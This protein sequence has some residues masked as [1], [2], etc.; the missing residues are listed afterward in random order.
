MTLARSFFI[1]FPLIR[2]AQTQTEILL[3]QI[4]DEKAQL[5]PMTTANRAVDEE[6]ALFVGK[7]Q[8]FL[9]VQRRISDDGGLANEI[10]DLEAEEADLRSQVDAEAIAQ[11]KE[12]ALLLIQNTRSTMDG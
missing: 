6:R 4:R 10:A 7:L 1:V 5:E 9:R 11:R 3:R 8:E 2:R 12:D